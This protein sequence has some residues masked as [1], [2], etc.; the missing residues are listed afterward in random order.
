M[1]LLRIILADDCH[2]YHLPAKIWLGQRGT[3][4]GG[5]N[6]DTVLDLCRRYVY[7]DNSTLHSG[8]SIHSDAVN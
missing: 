5:S 4:A 7:F 8:I 3:V 1:L 2:N 6:S